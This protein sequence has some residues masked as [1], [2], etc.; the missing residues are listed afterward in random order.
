MK[1]LIPS[2]I[3]SFLFETLKQKS[4][5]D[6]L[7]RVCRRLPYIKLATQERCSDCWTNIVPFLPRR[8]AVIGAFSDSD[9]YSFTMEIK[10]YKK[11][12]FLD[13]SVPRPVN[14]NTTIKDDLTVYSATYFLSSRLLKQNVHLTFLTNLYASFSKRTLSF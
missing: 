13:M 4:H 8:L 12:A 6:C 11:A 9:P 3:K 1:L 7:V 5:V 14:L 10:N 2:H